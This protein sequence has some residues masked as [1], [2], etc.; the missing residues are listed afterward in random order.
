MEG[1]RGQD[2]AKSLQKILWIVC[3]QGFYE[4]VLRVLAH[5][6]D[7]DLGEEKL[8]EGLRELPEIYKLHQEMLGEMEEKVI[9]WEE[10]QKVADVFLTRES[11]FGCHTA[12][13][14]QF[15]RN[16]A[17]LDEARLKSSQLGAVI[18]EFEC[19]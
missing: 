5:K 8:Q 1:K 15:D 9:N 18:Q 6:G 16:L 14:M 7:N 13:I 19:G 3:S 12:F 11:R 17:L 2:L 4:A 10:H